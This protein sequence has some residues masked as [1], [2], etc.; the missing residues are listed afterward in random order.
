M[1]LHVCVTDDDYEAWR[2]VRIAVMPGEDPGASAFAERFGFVEVDRQIEQVRKVS[3]EA[4]PSPLPAELG[5][6]VVVLDQHP[7]LWAASFDT[8]GK[9]V[10][11]DLALFEPLEVRAQ[12]WNDDWAGAPMFLALHSGEVIGC[13]GLRRDWCGRGIA[14]HLKRRTLRWAA[15]NGLTE[16]YPWT[17]AGNSSMLRLNEHLG[18]TPGRVSITVSRPLP[19]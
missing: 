3:D 4:M 18:Y 1:D 8:F 15:D 17:Q 11:A 5:V 19:L 12:E 7:E 14:S 10:P 9:V 2:Q 16:V 6:E 13:A